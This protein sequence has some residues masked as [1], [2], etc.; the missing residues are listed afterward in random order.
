MGHRFPLPQGEGSI[1]RNRL[2]GIDEHKVQYSDWNTGMATLLFRLAS[3]AVVPLHEHTGVELTYVLR[4]SLE[5]EEGECTAGNTHET[6]A[7]RGALLP[8]V[9]M[10]R[11]TSRPASGSSPSRTRADNQ[12]RIGGALEQHR[13]CVQTGHARAESVQ[14]AAVTAQAVAQ[15]GHHPA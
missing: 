12:G 15:S 8:G 13:L 3:G 7:P 10:S 9:F 11:T 4:G 5:D 14:A 2:I 6:R 1:D